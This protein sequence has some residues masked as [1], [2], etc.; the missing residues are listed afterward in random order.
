MVWYMDHGALIGWYLNG[1][2]WARLA[3]LAIT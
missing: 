3:V 2:S 1:E